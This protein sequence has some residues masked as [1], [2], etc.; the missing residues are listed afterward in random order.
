MLT[1]GRVGRDEEQVVQ[2]LLELARTEYG[3][4]DRES[5]EGGGQMDS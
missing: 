2:V 1:G 3:G 5:Y 4:G